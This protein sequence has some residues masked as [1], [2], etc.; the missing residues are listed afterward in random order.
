MVVGHDSLV[1]DLE[2]I[3]RGREERIIDH[4]A[5]FFYFLIMIARRGVK[6]EILAYNFIL[7]YI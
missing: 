7:N 4:L 2:K 1:N 3:F 5:P 6:Y